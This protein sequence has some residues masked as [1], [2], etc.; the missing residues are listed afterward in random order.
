M[1]VTRSLVL[2]ALVLGSVLVEEQANAVAQKGT[3]TVDGVKSAGE[4]DFAAVEFDTGP[5]PCSASGWDNSGAKGTFAWDDNYVYALFEAYPNTCGAGANPNGPFDAVNLEMYVNALGSAYFLS[6]CPDYAPACSSPDLGEMVVWSADHMLI[7]MKVPIADIASETGS[8]F[9]PPSDFL[10]YRVTITD[11]DTAGGFD[12]RDQT[13]GWVTEPP[14]TSGGYRKLTFATPL[15]DL[16]AACTSG[17]ECASTFCA[18]GVCCN[19]PCSNPGQSCNLP[20]S[21]GLCRA[22]ISGVP[23]ASERGVVAL[24]ALLAAVGVASLISVRRRS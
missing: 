15:L 9:S 19:V 1:K 14:E 20:G 22:E 13:L 5:R 24:C 3:I 12:S 18:S 23:A 8:P 6:E 11:P 7:E 21:A 2:A 4:W 16:G 10:E 17:T